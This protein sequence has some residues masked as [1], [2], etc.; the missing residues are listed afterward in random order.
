MRIAKIDA[1][2][3]LALSILQNGTLW[4]HRIE[5]QGLKY[6]VENAQG[7]KNARIIFCI[8]HDPNNPFQA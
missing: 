7:S 6:A 2:I 8:L 4:R 1:R 3:F 5:I